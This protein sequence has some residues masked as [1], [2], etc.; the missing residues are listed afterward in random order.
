MQFPAVRALNGVSLSFEPGQVHGIVGENGAGKST[1]VKIL[2]GIQRATSGEVWIDEHAFPN[3]FDSVGQALRNGIAMIH[4]ELNLVAEL[5]AA[6]NIFLNREPTRLGRIDHKGLDAR[7]AEW[8]KKVNA[9][10]DATAIV[11]DLSLAQQQLVEIAKAL[12]CEAQVLI[13][14]EPTA[15]LSEQET[16]TLFE[17]VRHLRKEGKT[18]IYISHRLAEVVEI[19]DVVTVF[20]DGELIE[21][22]SNAELDESR[23]ANLMVGRELEEIFPPRSARKPGEVALEVQELSLTS[24]VRGASLT[25]RK[26]EIVGLAG[27]IGSGRT[28]FCEAIFGLRKFES[29]KVLVEGATIQ[30]KSP[31]EAIR[32]KIAYV[33][34]D[35]KGAGLVLDMSVTQ[36]IT[37][38]N[39]A[40]YARPNLVR[41]QE[42]AASKHW[43]DKLG[44]R[45]GDPDA[46]TLFL[47]GGNQQKVAIAKWLDRHPQVLILDEPT[48]GVDVG[49][50]SEIYALIHELAL[51]GLACL[52][53]S[54]ELPELIGLCDRI[55]VMREGRIVGEVDGLSA[56]EEALMHLA[57]G[58]EAA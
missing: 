20:R 47:S 3:G 54:S 49:A 21:T 48:R 25:V 36:N 11:G 52:V 19:C 50:K 24:S 46:P 8:L 28:E 33:S 43:I 2:A 40:R 7:A 6:Q 27:L 9:S 53:V 30:P 15:V 18:V 12:S 51:E 1:L 22:L 56:T 37:L 55:Y 16:G 17:L 4:Q 42:M 14:D 44:I 45:V 57:A 5:T 39:F 29:G 32:H 34:E 58:V 41:A 13:M 35:R 38:A 26:G 23:I 31:V 10:F